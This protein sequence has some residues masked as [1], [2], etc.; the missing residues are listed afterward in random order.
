MRMQYPRVAPTRGGHHVTQLFEF[1]FGFTRLAGHGVE[2]KARYQ[3]FGFL[4]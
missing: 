1:L 4:L 2:E 3:H